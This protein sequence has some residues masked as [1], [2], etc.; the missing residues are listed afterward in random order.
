MATV[1]KIRSTP[2]SLVELYVAIA[3]LVIVML[4][5]FII[6]NSAQG[7][8]SNSVDRD[9]IYG[10]TRVAF[11]LLTRDLQSSIYEEDKVFFW[12]KEADEI[13]FVAIADS[14]QVCEIRYRLSG[15]KIQRSC[16]DSGTHNW[17][18]YGNQSTDAWNA[19]NYQDIISYVTG[20]K[21][22]C[23]DKE[24]NKIASSLS[25]STPYPYSVKI[26]ITTLGAN[27][28]RKWQESALPSYKDNNERTFSKTI[29]LG[30]R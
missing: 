19:G 18:F 12:H 6:I 5:M 30:D 1:R 23:F 14:S 15:G 3:L 27:A 13:S 2:F 22:T 7:I 11:D 26:D 8:F 28:Y 29:Y 10:N 21:L 17:N 24:G 25:N 9:N 4:C 20:F 16:V